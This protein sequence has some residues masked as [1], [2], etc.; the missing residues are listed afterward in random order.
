MHTRKKGLLTESLACDYLVAQGLILIERN[1]HSRFGEI[2]LIL[3]QDT[4]WVF[5]EVRHRS[6]KHASRYGGGVNSINTRKKQRLIRTVYFY[7]QSRKLQNS[8]TRID[9]VDVTGNL[10]SPEFQWITNAVSADGW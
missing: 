8:L 4:C 9:M 3:R 1:F 7:I 5:V 10:E 2:D 6:A